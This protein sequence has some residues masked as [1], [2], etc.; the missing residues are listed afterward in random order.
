MLPEKKLAPYDVTYACGNVS[1]LNEKDYLIPLSLLKRY[2]WHMPSSIVPDRQEALACREP[3]EII[4]Y[5]NAITLH[6][7]DVLAF[8]VGYIRTVGKLRGGEPKVADVEAVFAPL[9]LRSSS[10]YNSR[11]H[12]MKIPR[13]L[14]DEIRFLHT[15]VRDWDLDS[16][17]KQS[18]KERA[19][20]FKQAQR[21]SY[22]LPPGASVD[23]PAL[24]KL[25]ST[26]V[27]DKELRDSTWE[28]PTC[29]HCQATQAAW[30]VECRICSKCIYKFAGGGGGGSGAF[31]FPPVEPESLFRYLPTYQYEV[32]CNRVSST[33]RTYTQPRVE[34]PQSSVHWFQDVFQGKPHFN[35]L[36][37]DPRKDNKTVTIVSILR[38][39]D[40]LQESFPARALILD[41]QEGY[42]RVVIEVPLFKK[43]I[44][45]PSHVVAAVK[46][47]PLSWPADA[48]FTC[49]DN[50]KLADALA[51]FESKASSNNYKFGVLYLGGGQS[52]EE[53]MYN[54]HRGSE[55][56]DYFLASIANKVTLAEHKGFRGGLDC[57]G[58]NTTGEFSFHTALC[59]N[60][61]GT[62]ATEE[63][64]DTTSVEI[65]WHVATL[66]PFDPDNVQQL[67]R[68][69]HLGNDLVIVVF[70]ES[71]APFDPTTF[72]SQFNH[73][74]IVVRPHERRAD[75]TPASYQISV[76]SKLGV[77]PFRPF[78]PN[79]PIL[80]DGPKFREWFLL[81][82][83]NAEKAAYF[84]KDFSLKESRTRTKM[85]EHWEGTYMEAPVSSPS[86]G[87]M[88]KLSS[89]ASLLT[90]WSGGESGS[91]GDAEKK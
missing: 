46:A 65:M 54:N 24:R 30:V 84:A 61:D 5:A 20:L 39:P 91:G 63:G 74:W 21:G 76:V 18:E 31:K 85:F 1:W 52:T 29:S 40:G 36:I 53:Q 78:L 23:V 27:T 88:Q 66:L 45:D 48:K 87:W 50:P 4:S 32:G 44:L 79:P 55:A 43:K 81:K 68:K 71:D 69:R 89:T 75:R 41:E 25:C 86:G 42:S 83:I 3:Q 13:A 80:E 33:L 82:C 90:S 15:L 34:L 47:A 28:L 58:E 16:I 7:R 73:V 19:R 6:K 57:K 22:A 2:M 17:A 62:L 56:Y 10:N 11:D 35:I 72:A 8:V 59:H 26:W 70:T 51:D 77:K 37:Q 14:D 60:L 12:K 49:I 38:P 64:L 9:V 67:H